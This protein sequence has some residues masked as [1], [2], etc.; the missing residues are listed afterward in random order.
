[1]GIFRVNTFFRYPYYHASAPWIT[2]EKPVPV[3]SFK[4][5][6]R[7]VTRYFRVKMCLCYYCVNQVIRAPDERNTD[8]KRIILRFKFYK[9]QPLFHI[10]REL[11]STLDFLMHGN[12]RMT[13]INERIPLIV[14]CCITTH[15]WCNRFFSSEFQSIIEVFEIFCLII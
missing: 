14:T 10:I 4:L 2:A 6:I 12:C 3:G 8:M 7:I 15:P 1:M 9:I 5:I 11:R 13:H